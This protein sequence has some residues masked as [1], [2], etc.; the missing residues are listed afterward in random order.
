MPS[1]MNW[2]IDVEDGSGNS[3]FTLELPSIP[4]QG[5]FFEFTPL[6]GATVKYR[7]D[8]TNIKVAEVETVDTSVENP[9]NPLIGYAARVTL[10]V[11]VVS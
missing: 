1:F 11:S 10:E 5:D 8:D 7:V 3:L 2:Y 4:V 9:E 6:E